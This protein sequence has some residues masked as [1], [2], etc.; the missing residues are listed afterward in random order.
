VEAAEEKAR[1][2]ADPTKPA[3][4]A[5]DSTPQKGGGPVK[6][7]SSLAPQVEKDPRS[8]LNS[9]DGS[10]PLAGRG[11]AINPSNATAVEAKQ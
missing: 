2:E 3:S 7:N 10:W 1:R 6:E 4:K 5:A 9:Q 11:A 8:G